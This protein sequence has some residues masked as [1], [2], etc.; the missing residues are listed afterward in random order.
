[1]NIARCATLSL[2]LAALAGCAETP[3]AINDPGTQIAAN[4]TI[5][6]VAPAA[7]VPVV[8]PATPPAT[9]EESVQRLRALQVIDVGEMTVQLPAEAT[10]C[11]GPCP[12]SEGVIA[13][14][15]QHAADHLADFVVR[16]ERAAAGPVQPE[17]PACA[18]DAI[19]ANITALQGLRVIEVRALIAAQPTNTAVPYARPTES[20]VAAA[21]RTTCERAQRL[22]AIT[23]ATR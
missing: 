9:P 17:S 22:A 4:N 3:P 23:N 20:D 19:A 8:V 12:G 16:A 14:A 10:N 6:T 2:S 11:Y 21:Q 5:A 1:M 7:V 15:R 13:Q 18:T